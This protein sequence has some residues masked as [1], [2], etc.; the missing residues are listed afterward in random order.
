MDYSLPPYAPNLKQALFHASPAKFK[1]FLGGVGSG[2]TYS[3]VRE[4]VMG[5]LEN[6]PDQRYIIGA[7]SNRIL[8]A[9]TWDAYMEFLGHCAK[10]NGLNLHTK[11]LQ[12]NQNRCIV[13]NGNI[14]FEF[15]TL[16]YAHNFAGPTIA[17]FHI[18]EGALLRD[19]MAAWGV[20]VER[21]RSVTAQRL[22][23]IVTTTPRGPI[24]VVQH[25][26]DQCDWDDNAHKMGPRAAPEYHLTKSTT[27]DNLFHVGPD[28]IRDM[29]T[30][31]SRREI[32]QQL[33]AKILDYEGAVYSKAF[34][35][36]RSIARSWTDA[37]LEGREKYIAIDWGPNYPHVLFICHD[38]DEDWNVVFDEFCEDG[39]ST[40][41]LLPE[42]LKIAKERYGI[43]KYDWD[44][45]YCD[46][47]PPSS[48]DFARSFFGRPPKAGQQRRTGV[49]W[50]PVRARRLSTTEDDFTD[51]IE[52]TDWCLSEWT[53]DKK[54][55]KRRIM[56]A[57]RLL[58]G[59]SRRRIIQ[60]MR[61]YSWP[62]KTTQG[63]R[64][65]DDTRRPVKG[66]YDHGADA[67]RYFLWQRYYRKRHAHARAA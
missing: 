21:L 53:P 18:D 64:I 51:G 59:G 48:T 58:R 49:K 65:L 60:C 19:G 14:R 11:T 40:Q 7:P 24:G 6:G 29:M 55:P 45:V 37:H 47:N 52:T 5:A 32:E 31:R 22:F 4:M 67:L 12:S 3:G 54:A 35:A 61:L 62:D 50:V 44:G 28:Y 27:W 2:K 20:M 41:D 26:V 63:A 43:D 9:A 33:S 16:K 57:P 66:V 23:G 30:G 36:T 15:V 39:W 17:G 25:F 38:P 42:I 10:V 46:W 56:F 34:S 1:L 13:L 8:E